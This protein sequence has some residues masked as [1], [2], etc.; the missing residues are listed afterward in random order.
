MAECEFVLSSVNFTPYQ[1]TIADLAL[2]H[3]LPSMF[4]FP[5]YVEA[6]GLMS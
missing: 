1:R 3:S 4:I 5:L 6:G 2:R